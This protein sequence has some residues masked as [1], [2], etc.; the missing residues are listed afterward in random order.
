MHQDLVGRLR[1]VCLGGPKPRFSRMLERQQE[2]LRSA[3]PRTE[4][5]AALPMPGAA[6]VQVNH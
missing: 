5:T 3:L 1:D 2:W 4:L 6:R